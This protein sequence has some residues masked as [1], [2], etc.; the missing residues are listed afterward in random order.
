MRN[1]RASAVVIH[2]NKVLLIHRINNGEEYYVS[3][4]G[5]VEG[6]ETIEEAALR[7]LKE[8]TS[9]KASID[10]LIYTWKSDKSDHKQYYY[11]CKY[12][13]G[14]PKI[15]KNSVE[16]KRMKNGNN[17]FYEPVWIDINKLKDFL[18]YPEE[19]KE[20]ILNNDW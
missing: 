5:A 3:P 2:N 8:E 11:L 4:G 15:D 9:V 6:N 17:D 14:K 13:S 20:K 16:A 19:L 18:I 1:I 12:I 7:E 10:K